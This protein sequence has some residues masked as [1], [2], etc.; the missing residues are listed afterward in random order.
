[1][2]QIGI[3]LLMRLS[4]TNWSQ[5]EIN[6]L[7][8]YLFEEMNVIMNNNNKYAYNIYKSSIQNS[9]VDLIEITIELS[10]LMVLLCESLVLGSGV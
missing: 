7:K 5:T 1:M 10:V 2:V 4:E 8:L 9:S 6:E 3:D